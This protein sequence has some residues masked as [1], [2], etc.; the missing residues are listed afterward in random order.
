MTRLQQY[1]RQV[2]PVYGPFRYAAR[3][4]AFLMRRLATTK[5]RLSR[6][7]LSRHSSLGCGVRIENPSQVTIGPRCR[8]EDNVRITS[9]SASGFL[10]LAE[11]VQ[12]NSGATLDHTGNLTLERAAL[13]SEHAIIYTHDH[14]YDPRSSPSSSP[15][16]IGEGAWIG[17][18]AIVMPG[19]KTIGRHS[20]IAAGAVVTRPVP[21]DTV[22]AGV[23]ARAIRTLAPR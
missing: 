1:V 19:V 22:V 8:I 9:E 3:L 23:P 2:G 15:L 5:W 11:D 12:V 13:I 7:T 4:L 20:I 18:R 17:A 14:G 21:A 10:L 6:I 16:V